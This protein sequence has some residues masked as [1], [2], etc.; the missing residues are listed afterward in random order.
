MSECV[1][2]ERI[3]WI[4]YT[5]R[6]YIVNILRH[7]LVYRRDDIHI[8]VFD[9]SICGLSMLIR[10]SYVMYVANKLDKI[11]ALFIINRLL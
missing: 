11:C 3:K 2:Y 7:G 6:K 10:M 5:H 9:D 8:N 4:E 1:Y